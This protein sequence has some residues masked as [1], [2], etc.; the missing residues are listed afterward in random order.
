MFVR[1]TQMRREVGGSR[2]EQSLGQ[3][4]KEIWGCSGGPH[5]GPKWL[6][7]YIPSSLSSSSGSKPSWGH[8]LETSADHR[9]AEVLPKASLGGPWLTITQINQ[10]WTPKK[11]LYQIWWAYS[12]FIWIKKKKTMRIGNTIWKWTIGENLLYQI[13]KY[14]IKVQ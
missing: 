4:S 3:P 10:K 11:S 12:N 5:F 6:D 1:G 8:W 14:I 2:I 7:F 13:L 9:W